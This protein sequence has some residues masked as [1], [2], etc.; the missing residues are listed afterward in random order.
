MQRFIPP[1]LLVLALMATFIAYRPGLSG[2]FVFDDG[3]NVVNNSHI[4]IHDLSLNSLSEAAF[5][6]P[7]GLLMRPISMSS[8]ALNYYFDS[9]P[10]STF[11]LK[12]T[13]LVI[14]LFN[15]LALFFFIRKLMALYRERRQPGLPSTYPEWLAL[16]VASAWLLHPLNL[17]S[18][19]YVVQRMTSLA[20]LFT[21]LGLITYLWGRARLF[22]GQR[23]SI[24]A[25]LASLLVFAPLAILSK[26]NGA[27]LPFF[28]LA[29][30]LTLFKF[31]TAAPA[32]RR[33]LIGFFAACTLLPV[34]AFVVYL[35]QHPDWVLAGYI[36]RDFTLAERLMTE[37]RVIWFYLRLIVLPSVSQM[38]MYHDD[39]AI[40]RHLLDP[41]ITLPA[42]LSTFALLGSTWLLRR[43]MPLAAF[44]ILFFL[45]GHSMEST[46]LSLEIAH[47]H[48]NYLPMA[49]IL[50]AFFHAL[51]EPFHAAKARFMRRAAAVLLIAL[52]AGS[53]FSRANSW[54]NSLDL[55]SAEV[56][57]H[58]ASARANTE[59]G[60]FIEHMS[61]NDPLA[62]EAN[63]PLARHYFERA[64]ALQKNNVNG[65]FGLIRLSISSGKPV[66]QG[67]LDEL[68]RRLEQEAIP[69]NVNDQLGSLAQC[70]QQEA[71]PLTSGQFEQLLHAS[72]R[73]AKTSDWDKVVIN[74][75]TIYYLFNISRDY[76]AA[77]EAARR[78]IE[79]APRELE[80]RVSLVTILI[81]MQRLEEAR[82]QLSQLK[83]LD[84]KGARTRNIEDL[85]KKLA[86]GS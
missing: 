65:L 61:Q 32:A 28:M 19:L 69:A 35:A 45:V 80:S 10:S 72:L 50:L 20:T 9:D 21:L 48:R 33:F 85:E 39:I 46:F 59:L 51:I 31:E 73:N 23:G 76:P 37:S 3:I 67:W 17:T 40:S 86:H 77:L 15:G 36:R 8:F 54:A 41:F 25:I 82:D 42:L 62:M 47:E 29:I 71:C 18:V 81:A 1:I 6:I 84:R 5:S 70:L 30:E 24:S 34:L 74:S 55:W 75:I 66:E 78:S 58:P 64:A 53:T 26:E 14:H 83:A 38:G 63:Y 16:A 4:K 11:S 44:G 7:S 43:R 57:H 52:F 22:N 49:G 13:N 60:D 12:L 27:L 68:T 79:W 2:P 56:A